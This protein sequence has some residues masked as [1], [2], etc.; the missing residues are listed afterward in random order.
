HGTVERSLGAIR[1]EGLRPMDRHHIHLSPDIP[2]A[3]AVG[4]RRGKPVVLGIDAGRMHAEGHLFFRAAN[5]VWLTEHVPPGF[6]QE[7]G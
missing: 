5:G 2:T 1:K 3:K 7:H 6:I 4:S